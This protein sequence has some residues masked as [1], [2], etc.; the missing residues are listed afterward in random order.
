[1]R[2][3]IDKMTNKLQSAFADA[4][5]LALKKE[6]RQIDPLH[7]LLSLIEQKGGTIR[8]LLAQIGFKISELA[9]SYTHLTLPTKA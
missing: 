5:S 1:M 3:R 4:Q 6:N 8:P 9:V 2:M 7:L